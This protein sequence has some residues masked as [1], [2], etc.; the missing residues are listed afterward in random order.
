MIIMNQSPTQ[1]ILIGIF[2]A[3]LSLISCIPAS[4]D[5]IEGEL[6]K[7]HRITLLFEG[8]QSSEM[9]EEN[10]FLNYRLDVTFTQGEHE[11]VVPGFYA[12]DGNAAETSG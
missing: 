4:K 3:C 6:K 8:P 10:P 9:D 1:R 5:E 7:W 2:L 11:F 12:A